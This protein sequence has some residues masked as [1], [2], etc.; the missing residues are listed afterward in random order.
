MRKLKSIIIAL[1]ALVFIFWVYDHYL[2]P[3][4]VD[5]TLI[6]KEEGKIVYCRHCGREMSRDVHL[7]SVSR[8]EAS[9]HYVIRE[10][11]VCADCRAKGL[12]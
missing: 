8:R 6:K 9:R 7:V 5:I 2:K 4:A 12:R 3:G 10:Q 11:S 1:I